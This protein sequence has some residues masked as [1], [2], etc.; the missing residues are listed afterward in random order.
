MNTVQTRKPAEPRQ[1]RDPDQPPAQLATL[2]PG[3]ARETAMALLPPIVGAVAG[4][5]IP[6]AVGL[7]LA[8]SAGGLAA[9]VSAMFGAHSAWYLS[10]ASAFAAYVLLWWSMVL[11]L[12]LTNRLAR[13]W[14]GGPTAN[15][16][17]EHASLLGLVFGMLHAFVLLG[18]SYIGYTLPQILIPFAGT[19]AP[20]WVGLGQIGLYLM[21]LVTVTFY[22]RR[23]IG[24][25]WRSIHYLSF[26]V[27]VLAL[28]HGLFSGTDT[29]AA[30]AF[31]MYAGTGLAVIALTIYRI[32]VGRGGATPARSVASP[33]A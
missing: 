4:I 5:G 2:Q 22:L 32:L 29:S 30:W 13:I 14:P 16:L 27:F 12:T 20:L 9:L 18:D 15:D 28:L 6:I 17:H 21:A 11:G 3:S 33:S 26:G 8:G 10:R 23:W 7:S 19:Y 31:W 25:A 24:R 1:R